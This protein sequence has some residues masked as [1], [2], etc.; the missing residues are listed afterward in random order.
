MVSSVYPAN[1]AVANG[2]LFFYGVGNQT[3]LYET[4]GTATGTTQLATLQDNP[5][6]AGPIVDFAGKTWF[7]GTTQGHAALWRTD[8]TLQGTAQF[9]PPAGDVEGL[10]VVDHVL[11]YGQDGGL[12]F[13]DGVSDADPVRLSLGGT[14]LSMTASG[15]RLFFAAPYGQ[16]LWTAYPPPP[17]P[18]VSVSDVSD[19][20]VTITWS[21]PAAQVTPTSAFIVE[22]RV[23]PG[24]TYVPIAD[25]P[26][27]ANT[28]I[29]TSVQAGAW[30]FYRVRAVNAGGSSA[31]AGAST[32]TGTISGSVFADSNND[33]VRQTGEGGIAG[34]T[35]YID[36]NGS[37]KLDGSDP[38]TVTDSMGN[39]LFSGLP[40]GTYTVRQVIPNGE[41][42]TSPLGYSGIVTLAN[43]QS[44]AGPVFGDVLVSAVRLDFAYLVKLARNYGL[45]GTFATGD[46]NGDGK[47]DFRDLVI[48]ARNYGKSLSLAAADAAVFSSSLVGTVSSLATPSDIGGLLPHRR[49]R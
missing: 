33:G 14:P 13:T 47:V 43:G 24:G 11:L 27:T 6:E 22:R 48:L 37:G 32:G 9:G 28:F 3:G 34:V 46:L 12:W 23:G 8:G 18:V 49:R 31:S 21:S 4:D 29:D 44:A 25:L 41:A 26:A 15:G 20:H 1:L 30:Y 36:L 42:A 38:T 7:V 16:Q 5:F 40:A 35:V 39:Y 2:K 17:E 19:S 10:T 45:P